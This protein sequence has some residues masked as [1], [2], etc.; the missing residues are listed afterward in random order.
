MAIGLGAMLPGAMDPTNPPVAGEPTSTPS[1][2][3]ITRRV[4]PG[5]ETAFEVWLR[6]VL[7]VMAGFPGHHSATV[8]RPGPGRREYVLLIRW[9]S[10]ADLARW[11]GSDEA[12]D[13]IGRAGPLTESVDARELHGLEAWFDLPGPR[14]PPRWKMAVLT[15]LA[16]YPL[17]L[18]LSFVLAPWIAELPLPVRV[19]ITAGILV[20]TM[21]WI[22]MPWLTGR[23][24]GW[25]QPPTR[26]DASPPVS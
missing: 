15:W 26:P 7:A 20:P 19:A 16:I 6:G 10:A 14:P 17:I 25:L 21:T 5:S 4:R 13:W 12:R 2:L 18:L 3:L 9:S 23:F 1:T 8:I 11:R 24:V 22:M